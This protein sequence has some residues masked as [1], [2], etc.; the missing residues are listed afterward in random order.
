MS[1]LVALVEHYLREWGSSGWENAYH[2]VVELGPQALPELE[3]AL[4]KTRDSAF[5]A[6]LVEMAR[7][8][9]SEDA[10][11]LFGI[12][13]RDPSPGVWKAALDGLVS[14][15]SSA[16]L[17]LLQQAAESKPPGRTGVEEWRAWLTEALQQVQAERDARG[18]AA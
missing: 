4:W 12:A 14:L 13:L 11:P 9:H 8:I 6:A 16:S 5:R 2:A 7:Q 18:G 10:L 15:A 17:H 3:Q 1:E